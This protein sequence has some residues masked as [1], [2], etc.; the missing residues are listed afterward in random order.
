MENII[1]IVH[2]VVYLLIS[3]ALT[4]WVGR[5]LLKN[6]RIFLVEAFNGNESMADS[7]NHL[8]IVGFYLISFGILSLFLRYGDKP[9]TIVDSIELMSTKIGVVLLILG[10]VHISNIFVFK[11]FDIATIIGSKHPKKQNLNAQAVVPPQS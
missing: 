3:A 9:L 6:S 4:V 11:V 5:T 2:Y 1:I 10:V 7:V 8:L